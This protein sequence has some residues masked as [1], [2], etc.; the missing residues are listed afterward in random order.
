M[1]FSLLNGELNG[2]LAGAAEAVT[3]A[4][5]S[6]SGNA[7]P[8]RSGG[9]GPMFWVFYIV[10]LVALFY[11]FAIRPNKKREQERQT[12]REGIKLGDWVVTTAGF[13]GKVV[14]IYAE[15][16]MI[17]F[18]T[19]KGITIPVRKEEV[20]GV[21]EPGLANEPAPVEVEDTPKKR[22]FGLFR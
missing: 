5:T 11:F 7:A 16:F 8:A 2:S 14:N 4:A 21:K 12:L 19:N 13:Y 1:L 22:K 20:V 17:E 18:G 3:K 10:C 9:L 15:E 6:A